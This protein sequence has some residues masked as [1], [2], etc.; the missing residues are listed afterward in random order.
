[1]IH[2]KNKI[3]FNNGQASIE[4][5]VVCGALV[6]ALLMP[7]NNQQNIMDLCI[8]ALRE[9]YTAFAYAK[10]LSALPN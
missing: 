1:M 6:A 10:S 7:V 3:S 5:L 2:F 4:Y 8:N 9:W